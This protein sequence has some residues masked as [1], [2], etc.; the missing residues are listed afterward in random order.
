[1]KLLF[2]A[3]TK[4]MRKPEFLHVFRE[5]AEALVWNTLNILI[6]KQSK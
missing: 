2:Y 6:E 3:P 5:Y 1:M 4:N